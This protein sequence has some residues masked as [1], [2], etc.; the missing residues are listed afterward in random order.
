LRG[1]ERAK[2]AEGE[3][4]RKRERFREKVVVSFTEIGEEVST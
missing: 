4:N 3:K 1:R 2:I